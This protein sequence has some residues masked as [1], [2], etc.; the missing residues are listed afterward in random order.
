MAAEDG[1]G[2]GKPGGARLG[3]PQRTCCP[4]PSQPVPG[5]RQLGKHP[6]ATHH[7][8]S[9]LDGQ[10]EG[11]TRDSKTVLPRQGPEW[12]TAGGVMDL[13]VCCLSHP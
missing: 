2:W 10:G 11:G 3:S 6:A 5:E 4:W 12:G 1:L 8:M 9:S 7:G 13:T